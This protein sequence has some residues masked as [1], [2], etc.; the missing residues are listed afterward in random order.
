VRLADIARPGD[1][2]LWKMESRFACRKCRQGKAFRNR[3]QIERIPR[4]ANDWGWADL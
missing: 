4:S 3:A 1:E 2:P